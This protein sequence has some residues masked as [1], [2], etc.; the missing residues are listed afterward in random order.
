MTRG[1]EN[2]V[3]PNNYACIYVF[4]QHVTPSQSMFCFM[5]VHIEVILDKSKQNND[6]TKTNKTMSN[7]LYHVL[8][9]NVVV[10]VYDDDDDEDEEL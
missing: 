2:R 6:M 4:R 10:V 7:I 1:K 5:S 9:R 8:L 3:T